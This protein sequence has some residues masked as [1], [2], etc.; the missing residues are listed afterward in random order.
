ME[1]RGRGQFVKNYMR[2]LE[3]LAEH[4]LLDSVVG[5]QTYVSCVFKNGQLD[6]TTY[7]SPE[8]LHPQHMVQQLGR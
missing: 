8:A 5:L 1:S 6:I 7:M 4:R 2:V 3:G